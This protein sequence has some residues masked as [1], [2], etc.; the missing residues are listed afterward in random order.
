M[1]TA[2]FFGLLP[3]ELLHVVVHHLRRDRL[4]NET[5]P[6]HVAEAYAWRSLGKR[7][8]TASMTTPSEFDGHWLDGTL[9]GPAS[10]QSFTAL[11]KFKGGKRFTPLRKAEAEGEA[12]GKGDA[13]CTKLYIVRKATTGELKALTS[14]FIV[15]SPSQVKNRYHELCLQGLTQVLSGH[16]ESFDQRLLWF[17]KM[18]AG[19]KAFMSAKKAEDNLYSQSVDGHYLTH[20]NYYSNDYQERPQFTSS[21]SGEDVFVGYKP[22][23]HANKSAIGP[24]ITLVPTHLREN[25]TWHIDVPIRLTDG[26]PGEP[27]NV[28]R[29]A[30]DEAQGVL[31]PLSAVL[32]API[33]RWACATAPQWPRARLPTR[34][35]RLK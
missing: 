27:V 9:E 7:F 11:H 1:P 24:T 20:D 28:V 15:T 35:L 32:G 21:L 31:S 17:D 34:R 3:P 14:R 13:N 5:I 6:G 22:H 19:D 18:M 25:G 26:F 10:G 8:K 4:G 12:E 33:R 30:D 29:T 16:N 23:K 2:D